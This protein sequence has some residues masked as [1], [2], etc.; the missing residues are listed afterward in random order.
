[1]GKKGQ[2]GPTHIVPPHNEDLNWRQTYRRRTTKLTTGEVIEDV[3]STPELTGSHIHLQVDDRG[4]TN[5]HTRA[6]LPTV[7]NWCITPGRRKPS[8][9]GSKQQPNVSHAMV[10]NAH[11]WPSIPDGP[12]PSVQL[13]Y[14]H[15]A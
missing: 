2:F 15:G 13:S 10:E 14:V 5:Y 7:E 3:D 9:F 11:T 1:M 6:V 8:I 4:Q 12:S